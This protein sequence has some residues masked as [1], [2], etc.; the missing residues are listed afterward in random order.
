MKLPALVA[1]PPAATTRIGPEVAPGGTWVSN[2]VPSGTSW[3]TA[4]WPL[5]NT[6]WIT[7]R[8]RPWIVT[9]VP[10]EPDGGEKPSIAGGVGEASTVKEPALVTFPVGVITVIGPEV[11]TGKTMTLIA[12][13]EIAPSAADPKTPL[14]STFVA[15]PRFVPVI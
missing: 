7:L 5:K 10:T 6:F 15:R 3:N 12:V 8:L 2:R 4:T 11:A 13:S 9:E 1:V 14:N